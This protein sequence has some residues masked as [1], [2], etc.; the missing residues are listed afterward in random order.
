MARARQ[1]KPDN[2]REAENRARLLAAEGLAAGHGDDKPPGG[3]PD[4]DTVGG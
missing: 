4:D 2:Q 1:S 3:R